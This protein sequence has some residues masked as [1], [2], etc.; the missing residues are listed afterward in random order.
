MFKKFAT[1]NYDL[2]KK[3]LQSFLT[4]FI[5]KPILNYVVKNNKFKFTWIIFSN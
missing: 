3:L 5:N 4:K 2:Y 1:K